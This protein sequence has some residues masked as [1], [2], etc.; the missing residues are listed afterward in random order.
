MVKWSKLEPYAER[1]S[2][3]HVFKR[4]GTPLNVT[5]VKTRKG[6]AI[7]ILAK[8]GEGVKSKNV[9]DYIYK[10]EDPNLF[11]A[12]KKLIKEAESDA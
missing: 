11:K 3:E 1:E 4:K 9:Y 10:E 2:I 7:R 6:E 8:V 5:V 12:V